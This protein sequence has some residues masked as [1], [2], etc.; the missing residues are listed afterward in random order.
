[1][2]FLKKA[3]LWLQQVVAQ[4]DREML[5]SWRRTAHSQS[6]SQHSVRPGICDKTVFRAGV[7]SASLCV[8]SLQVSIILNLREAKSTAA[9]ALA[10]EKPGLLVFSLPIATTLW[11]TLRENTLH[12]H[13]LSSLLALFHTLDLTPDFSFTHSS[14]PTRTKNVTF[15]YMLMEY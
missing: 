10:L 9:K 6:P 3:Y 14:T 7:L 4:K 5:G 11:Q 1:M 8:T 15:T 12:T 13:S 2:R